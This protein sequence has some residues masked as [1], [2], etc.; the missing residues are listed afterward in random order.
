MFD[1]VFPVSAHGIRKCLLQ[2]QPAAWRPSS[3]VS[4]IIINQVIPKNF[5]RSSE[6]STQFIILRT[7]IYIN[8]HELTR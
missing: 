6:P 2:L 4:I 7:I 8:Y 1:T 3:P 5:D